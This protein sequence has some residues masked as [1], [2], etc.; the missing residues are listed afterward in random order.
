LF[1][2][3]PVFSAAP[4]PGEAQQITVTGVVVERTQ[5]SWIGGA[6]VRLSGSPPFFTDL[7]GAFRFSGVIPGPHTLT[8]QALGYQTLSAEVVVRAD[9]VLVVRMDPDPIVLDSLLVRAGNIRIR[10][11]VLD[12][13]TG[14]RV[15]FASVRVEP[16]FSSVG[17]V[18]GS[19]TIKKIPVGR[20][21][22]L[23]VE[24]V[25]YLPARIALITEADTSLTI[26]LEP[27]PVGIRMLELQAEKLQVR[28]SAIAYSRKVL[29]KEEL[30]RWS[31]WSVFEIVERQL[32]TIGRRRSARLDTDAG[33]PK[34]LFIDDRQ[35]M[36]WEFLWGLW[37]G[38]VARIEFFDRGEMVRIY[39]KRYLLRLQGRDPP[40]LIYMKA[41][42]M[43]TVCH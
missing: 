31:S 17:A 40:P 35:Q 36:F 38:E 30:A 19:F 12:A 15:L 25:E 3:L 33:P 23:I 18:S 22:S 9:T 14:Q 24:A 5:S 11:E 2:V 27:D 37:P 34:C 42:I 21:V 28:S 8:V 26:R 20:P 6:T 29:D 39:T 16:G 10:G 1:F 7:D 43:G 32:S 13:G 4:R 41:G